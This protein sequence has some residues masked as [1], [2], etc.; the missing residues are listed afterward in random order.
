MFSHFGH[1][2]DRRS[3]G[4]RTLYP[5]QFHL[6]AISTYFRAQ[7]IMTIDPTLVNSV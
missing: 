2:V 5:L 7:L 6:I 4:Y 3:R 1:S